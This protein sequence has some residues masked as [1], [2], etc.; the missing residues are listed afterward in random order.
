METGNT[1]IPDS[2]VIMSKN[3]TT[4]DIST[5]DLKLF[6]KKNSMVLAQNRIE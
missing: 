2:K 1:K 6:C 5:P 3:N 4:R